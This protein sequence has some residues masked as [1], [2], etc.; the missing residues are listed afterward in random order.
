MIHRNSAC[1]RVLAV[2]TMFFS[3]SLF[4]E[5]QIS[6]VSGELEDRVVIQVN[7]SS[8]GNKIPAAPRY[9]ADFESDSNPTNFGQRQTWDGLRG[10]Y[11]N[12][13]VRGRSAGSL[14]SDI[15]SSSGT[16]GPNVL[17]IN[18]DRWYAYFKRYY[19][20]DIVQDQGP[21]GFN[22][23]MN[24]MWPAESGGDPPFGNNI[25]VNYQGRD[26]LE[27]GRTTAE[28]T[29]VEG[30]HWWGGKYPYVSGQ[31][32]TEEIIYQTSTIDAQNGIF[33]YIRDGVSI[34]KDRLWRM[35]TTERPNRYEHFQFD[36]VSNGTGP[37][38]LWVFYDDIYL[39]DTWARVLL[40]DSSL[41]SMC[42]RREI[43]IPITWNDSQI[44]V[45][46]NLGDLNSAAQ[47]L[48]LYVFSS[49]GTYNQRGFLVKVCAKCPSS[50]SQVTTE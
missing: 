3:G 35:R 28:R 21:K 24:R 42:E 30:T 26:G 16:H 44:E 9:W 8:F 18:S 7:G 31:W 15:S 47:S 48:F 14:R 27:S 34:G 37:G 41:L 23:K 6:S 19:E 20:F 45:L 4:A 49:D 43:Q 39:D 10:E 50:P 33:H 38:P 1:D 36:Q 13:K 17:N 12:E 11:T 2:A 22:L 5:P 40:C 32:I 46:V 29:S 25:F